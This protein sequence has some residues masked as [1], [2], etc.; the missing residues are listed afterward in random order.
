M[1]LHY[2]FC[3]VVHYNTYMKKSI[4]KIMLWSAVAL[5]IPLLGNQFVEGW[6][7]G[8]GDFIFA[9]VFFVVMSLA[10]RFATKQVSNP[11]YRIAVGIAVFLAFA[12]V[13]VMLATG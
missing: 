8:V 12:S 11:K 2:L 7:W 10:I 1:R 9:W 4:L 13:W 3:G 6:N 5:I